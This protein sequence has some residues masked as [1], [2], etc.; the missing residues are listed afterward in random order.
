MYLFWFPN[1]VLR[2]ATHIPPQQ[3]RVESQKMNESRIKLICE[4][5]LGYDLIY[6][7]ILYQ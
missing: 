1:I 7:Y 4:D 2:S 5:D 3:Y 6:I